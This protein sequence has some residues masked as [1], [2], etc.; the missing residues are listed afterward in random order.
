MPDVGADP[1][2]RFFTP[3][4][5]EALRHLSDI[6]MPAG[7]GRPGA[8][9]ARAP[10]FLDF[11]ISDSPEDRQRMYRDG[12]DALNV[13]SSRRFHK[14]FAATASDEAA[15]V[16][17]PLNRP[18]QYDPPSDPLGRFLIAA[19]ADV[20]TATVNS[21]EYVTASSGGGRRF[22]GSGLYWYSLD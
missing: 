11:L 21:R 8:I 10:E 20:R 3:A 6:L 2:P 12:L 19:R 15:V 5:F 13:E 16:L 22:G 1:V 4:Q 14:D 18:W 17:A 9:E 7:D